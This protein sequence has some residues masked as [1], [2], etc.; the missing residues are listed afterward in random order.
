MK[1]YKI[2]I[3][4][5]IIIFLTTSCLDQESPKSSNSFKVL[6]LELSE[7][8]TKSLNLS[9]IA[10]KVEYIPLQ[11][12]DSSLL[13]YFGDF[14]ITKDYF[15]IKYELSVLKFN[16]EGQYL[17]N[18][19][20]VG[21]GPGEAFARCFAADEE[22]ELVYVFDHKINDI[23]IFDYNG[24]FKNA[25]KKPVLL[26]G[27]VL[28]SIGYFNNYLLVPISQGPD[29]KYLYSL[30]NLKTDSIQIIC[31]NLRTYDKSQ[32]GKF[33]FTPSDYHYQI[34]DTTILYKEHF[35]D[36]IYKVN[37]ALKQEPIYNINLG[38]RKLIWEDWRDH[39]MFET[40]GVRPKGYQVQSFIESKT[41]LF[42]V[43]T[44]FKESEIFVVYN[45]ITGLI[46]SYKNQAFKSAFSQVYIKNDLDYLVDFPPMNR[47]GYL[48]YHD[49]CLYGV[50]EAM[51]FAKGYKSATTETK[52]ATD[53]L[54]KMAPIFDSITEF[55]NPVIM[56]VYLK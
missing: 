12:K 26:P 47:S 27:N 29:A 19:F 40:S 56:K 41:F 24:H 30:Y 28:Y 46:R 34:T 55:S 11:T 14:V 20:E 6:Q 37:K 4:I 13:D 33:H 38:N 42:F 16:R 5:V 49:N 9:E 45:K 52:N 25:I 8:T 10:S 23:K 18:L 3:H 39:G 2:L 32:I 22:K 48:F 17:N 43:L 35:C 15:F 51:D 44:S 36:T 54:R 53:Y 1:Q 7:A 50:I 31:K 21:L